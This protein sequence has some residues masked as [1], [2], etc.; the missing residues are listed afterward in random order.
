MEH[1]LNPNVKE[2]EISGIR[3]FS[4]LVRLTYK[5][6]QFLD[7]TRGEYLLRQCRNLI[8]P[9]RFKLTRYSQFAVDTDSL[10][11]LEE[12]EETTDGETESTAE[13]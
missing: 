9:Y 3:K 13:A 7:E 4:N 12:R 1:L 5:D 6:G 2:I 10:R 8:K 11:L